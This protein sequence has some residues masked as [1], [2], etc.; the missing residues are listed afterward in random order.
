KVFN[1][2]P[3]GDIKKIAKKAI[4]AI[5]DNKMVVEI[6]TAGLRKKVNEF[7]PSITLLEMVKKSDIDITFGSDAH[8]K[9]QVGFHLK[10]AYNLAK[11]IG[12]KKVVY[13][14]NREKR[15]I[16]L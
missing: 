6:N 13:F 15:V 3:Q 16:E 8:S 14:E 11:Q 4:E 2:H 10:K 9:N 1:F 12:F 5:A 7:Y